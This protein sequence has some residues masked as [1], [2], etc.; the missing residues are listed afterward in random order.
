MSEAHCE[1]EL[2][3]LSPRAVE[4]S[5]RLVEL[6]RRDSETFH[7]LLFPENFNFTFAPFFGAKLVDS[8]THH[9]CSISGTVSETFA[10]Q[11]I[12]LRVLIVDSSTPSTRSVTSV[13]PS[14]RRSRLTQICSSRSSPTIPRPS[15]SRILALVQQRTSS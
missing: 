8:A 6:K 1:S 9:R 15:R 5:A 7:F 10:F 13:S 14:K 11:C 12:F 2:Q 3:S 4:T